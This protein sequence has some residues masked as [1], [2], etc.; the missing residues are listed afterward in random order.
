MDYSQER[1]TGTAL[2]T[3]VEECQCPEGYKGLSCENCAPGFTRSGSGLYLGTCTP[4]QCNGKS[5]T[6]DPENG[7]CSVKKVQN[8]IL[9]VTTIQDCRDYTTGS[10]C[11][12]C[13]PGYTKDPHRGGCMPD[14][15]CPGEVCSCDAK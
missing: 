11:E 14:S 8:K 3:A 13:S 1:N 5:S 15:G 9:I 4:C 12:Q 7:V 2:A 6:C 10:Q